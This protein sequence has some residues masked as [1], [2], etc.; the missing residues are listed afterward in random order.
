MRPSRARWTLL[1]VL[2]VGISFIGGAILEVGISRAYLATEL[3]IRAQDTAT[4]LG[5]SLAPRLAAGDTAGVEAV[6]DAIFDRGYL[7]SITLSNAG[8]ATLLERRLEGIADDVPPWFEHLV[9]VEAPLARTTLTDRWSQT[10]RL[11]LRAHPGGAYRLLWLI[12]VANGASTGL[13]LGVTAVLGWLAVRWT[14]R[15][16]ERA[17]PGKDRT[18]ALASIRRGRRGVR[19][20]R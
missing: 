11:A 7:Q 1:I 12:A 15:T 6:V 16:R 17:S 13:G 8:G 3:G 18:P 9:P 14:S 2:L 5:L 4:A 19:G 10:G 20:G